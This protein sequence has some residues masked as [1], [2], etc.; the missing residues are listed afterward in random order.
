MIRLL[1]I[2]TLIFLPFL[3]CS[4]FPFEKYPA[5]KYKEFKNWKFYDKTEKENKTHITLTIPNFFDNNDTVTIQLTTFGLKDSSIIRIYRNKTVIQKISEPMYFSDI[6]LGSEPARIADINGD[7]LKDIKLVASYMGCGSAALNVRV[8]YLFQNPDHHFTK[9]SF[10]DKSSES[11][12]ERDFDNDG[13]FEIITMTLQGYK[14]HSY[15]LYNL[16]NYTNGELISANSKDDYPIM[17]QFLYRNNYKI[18]NKV[19]RK[20]MKELAQTLP[21]GYEKK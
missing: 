2:L 1:R 10:F 9:I 18:T 11:R 4:Q 13:N 21:E 12:P 17:I 15:W 19:S 20:E 16:F 14:D 3:A 8:V 7:S 5:I 6:N